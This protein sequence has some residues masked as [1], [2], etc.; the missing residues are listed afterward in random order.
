MDGI[1]FCFLVT[2][3]LVKENIWRLWFDELRKLKIKYRILTHCSYY[4][5]IKSPWLRATLIPKEYIKETRW[6]YHSAASLSLYTYAKN[7]TNSCWYTF[8]S[9]S[10][11]PFVSPKRFAEYYNNYKN[12]TLMSYRKIWWD[13]KKIN[14]ANLYLLPEVFHYANHEWLILCREDLESILNLSQN[15]ME[16][17]RQM[18]SA[19]AADESL[20]SV[21]LKI[22]NNF[23]NTINTQTT[24]VD[25]ERTPNG[26]NP[27]TFIE[28]K[29]KDIEIV[30]KN[31]NNHKDLLFF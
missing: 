8:H 10:C 22:S 27:H 12:N 21:F 9:E 6:E 17:T 30:E 13:P 1:T 5:N 4:E 3:D 28:W 31:K 16:L 11:V 26:N 19:P 14:R 24:L 29:E 7:M 25:W 2:K 23:K 18:I 20:V 15:N